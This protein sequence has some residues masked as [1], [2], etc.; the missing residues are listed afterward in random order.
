MPT[1]P[2]A[3]G[4]DSLNHG[5]KLFPEKKLQGLVVQDSYGIIAITQ[6]N[7]EEQEAGQGSKSR[8][9]A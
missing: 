5:F 2:C 7:S 4:D 1:P 3:R 8:A 9:I 6:G